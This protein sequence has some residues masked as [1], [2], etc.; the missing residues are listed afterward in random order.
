MDDSGAAAA[1]TGVSSAEVVACLKMTVGKQFLLRVGFCC[2]GLLDAWRR[3]NRGRVPN[4]VLF[5][6]LTNG[7]YTF[8][9]HD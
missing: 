9:V 7:E 4:G 8:V 3:T 5:V 1:L 2:A 6:A